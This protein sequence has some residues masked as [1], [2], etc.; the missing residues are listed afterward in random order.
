MLSKYRAV[1]ERSQL[2]ISAETQADV[3]RVAAFVRI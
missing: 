2:L 1:I 3:T